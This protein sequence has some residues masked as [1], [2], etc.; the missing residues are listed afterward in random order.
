[1][2]TR[3]SGRGPVLAIIGGG[4]SGAATAFHLA[5]RL[6]AGAADI[7]VVEPREG[8]GYG[9]AYSTPDPSHRINVP[10]SRMTLISGQDS[11]F[12]DWLE[13]TGA[14]ANDAEA[15][16]ANGAL[17]PQR[18]VFGR[19]VESHLQPFLFGKTIRHL[20]SAVASAELSGE[21]YHLILADGGTLAADALVIA[22][23][24]P[25]PA[26]PLPL[27]SVIG[28]AGL[29]ANPYDLERLEAIGRDD[30]VLVVGTGLTSADVIA[31]LDRNGHRGRITALSPWLPVARPCG[32]A[33]RSD[34]RLH[35][36]PFTQRHRAAQAYPVDHRNRRATGRRLAPGARRRPATRANHL[37]G[38]AAR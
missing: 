3:E 34:R 4:F 22:T 29:V 33:C 36:P 19:Y 37:A 32:H 38:P 15:I 16:A 35:R 17:Y 1:M 24:H 8:L 7:V 30:H 12:A 5:R 13:Q 10:A 25:P 26:L 6:P 11:H 20:R 28:A 9:L 18:R 14:I 27:Q 21:G 31:T 2:S 23:T